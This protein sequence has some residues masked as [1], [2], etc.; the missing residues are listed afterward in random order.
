LDL[1]RNAVADDFDPLDDTADEF[2]S[3][4]PL[5]AFDVVTVVR[6]Q[7]KKRLEDILPSSIIFFP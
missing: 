4:L 5:D 3:G 1:A 7:P 2:G 6:S